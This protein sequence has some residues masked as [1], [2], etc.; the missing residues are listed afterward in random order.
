MSFV[1]A[2]GG[3]TVTTVDVTGGNRYYRS[4]ITVVGG[5]VTGGISAGIIAKPRT[6]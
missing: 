6:I 1:D 3:T 5:T 2:A 4:L